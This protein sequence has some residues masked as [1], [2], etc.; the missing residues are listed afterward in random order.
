MHEH[1]VLQGCKP[2]RL[3]S[4]NFW[5]LWGTESSYLHHVR[6]LVVSCHL[7]SFKNTWVSAA[8]LRPGVFN[9]SMPQLVWEKTSIEQNPKQFLKP[10]NF[11]RFLLVLYRPEYVLKKTAWMPW[12]TISEFRWWTHRSGKMRPGLLAWQGDRIQPLEV[13]TVGLFRFSHVYWR[14]KIRCEK[15]FQKLAEKVKTCKCVF[16]NLQSL[17]G[18]L[19]TLFESLNE[20]CQ[21]KLWLFRMWHFALWT[22]WWRPNPRP[23]AHEW[24]MK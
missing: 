19:S 17:L 13:P 16:S 10:P 5:S 18:M 8:F 15:L 24:Q 12:K 21:F 23:E 20:R 3:D 7:F 22:R 9:V 1:H 4:G 14:P 2:D 6:D 11:Q